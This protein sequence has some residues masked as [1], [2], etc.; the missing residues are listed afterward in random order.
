MCSSDLGGLDEI[1]DPRGGKPPADGG[2]GRR[3][4]DHVPDQPQA[5]EE[6]S[7]PLE[8]FLDRRLVDQHYRYVVLDRI[9]AVAR[10]AFQRGAILDECHGR[11]AR[12]ARQD[13]EELC[14]N[15]HEQS[16]AAC[17][18]VDVAGFSAGPPPEGG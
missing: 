7:Q 11:L 18:G 2:D 16:V 4:E 6:D 15:G 3:G 12:R 13:F 14:V 1:G 5:D 17:A 10:S 9:H 8:L